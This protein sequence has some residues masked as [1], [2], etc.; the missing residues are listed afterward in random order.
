MKLS[1][2]ILRVALALLSER[3]LMMP[4]TSLSMLLLKHSGNVSHSDLSSANALERAL[5]FA[6]KSCLTCNA[7][8]PFQCGT[9]HPM[10][11]QSDRGMP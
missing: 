4:V 11:R 9:L 5:D 6:M 3:V 8:A 10:T 1:A 2:S 7:P